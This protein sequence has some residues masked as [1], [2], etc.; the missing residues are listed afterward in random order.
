MKGDP[1]QPRRITQR[2]DAA[3]IWERIYHRARS[4]KWDASWLQAEAMFAQENN[5]QWPPR[6]LPLMPADPQDWFRKVRDIAPENLI[7]KPQEVT[8]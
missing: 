8:T 5:W 7:P 2:P 4:E 6:N 3:Q 1:F